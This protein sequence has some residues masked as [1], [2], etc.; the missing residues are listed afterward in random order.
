MGTGNFDCLENLSP[1]CGSKPAADHLRKAHEE[2][3]EVALGAGRPSKHMRVAVALAARSL[4]RT[5]LEPAEPP[6]P[7][8]GH[9][10]L[11]ARQPQLVGGGVEEVERRADAGAEETPS[12]GLGDAGHVGETQACENRDEVRVVDSLEA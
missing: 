9:R 6:Q 1:S 2:L 7:S 4:E 10:A 8:F 12:R 3:L 11:H 5:D